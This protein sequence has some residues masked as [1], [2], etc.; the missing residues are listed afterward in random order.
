MNKSGFSWTQV[1]DFT[2]KLLGAKVFA[3][4]SVQAVLDN[5]H[6][7]GGAKMMR[8]AW[9]LSMLEPSGAFDPMS[10]FASIAPQ[11]FAEAIKPFV[12]THDKCFVFIGGQQYYLYTRAP[13][14]LLNGVETPSYENSA[15]LSYILASS[16][17]PTVDNEQMAKVLDNYFMPDLHSFNITRGNCGLVV[18]LERKP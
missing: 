18:T 4:S 1:V 9:I 5:H 13:H 14:R 11:W 3:P 16:V 10:I 15:G 17:W 12:R 6:H 2:N 7:H 8:L